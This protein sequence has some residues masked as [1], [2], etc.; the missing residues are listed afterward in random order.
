M[1]VA[2]DDDGASGAERPVSSPGYR[3]IC[4]GCGLE[5]SSDPL[6]D[7]GRLSACLSCGETRMIIDQRVGADPPSWRRA[8]SA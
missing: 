2:G 6:V 1:S 5:S 7:G 3:A 8:T 4:L